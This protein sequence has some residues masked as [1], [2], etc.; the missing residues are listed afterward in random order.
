MV[1]VRLNSGVL[2][3]DNHKTRRLEGFEVVRKRSMKPDKLGGKMSP[4]LIETLSGFQVGE[5]PMEMAVLSIS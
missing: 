4:W 5:I 3:I 1:F 2:K